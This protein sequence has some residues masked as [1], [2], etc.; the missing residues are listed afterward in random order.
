MIPVAILYYLAFVH[1]ESLEYR[2]SGP[3][4]WIDKV[5]MSFLY[6][7]WV[8]GAYR[9]SASGKTKPRKIISPSN[10]FME[11]QHILLGL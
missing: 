2:N 3:Q 7:I 9:F 6:K 8:I 4:S 5:S 11:Q 10:H 1:H